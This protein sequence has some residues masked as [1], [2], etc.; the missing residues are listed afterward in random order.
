MGMGGGLLIQGIEDDAQFR[1]EGGELENVAGADETYRYP[2]VEVEGA[3]SARGDAGSLETGLGE[4]QNLR[5]LGYLQRAQDGA[6]VA[7]IIVGVELDVAGIEA[8]LEMGD[9]V[10]ERR[11]GVLDGFV[12]DGQEVGSGKPRQRDANRQE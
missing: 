10:V 9:G 5:R 8:P 6:E 12:V 2:V 7:K 11:F 1:V 3:G 4:N